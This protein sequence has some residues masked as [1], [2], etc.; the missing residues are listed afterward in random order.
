MPLKNMASK[1]TLKGLVVAVAVNPVEE[2]VALT[3]IVCCPADTPLY[4]KP[5]IP[6]KPKAHFST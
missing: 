3:V 1:S 2:L 5:D 6:T 4:W